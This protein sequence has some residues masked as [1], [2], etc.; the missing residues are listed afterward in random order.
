MYAESGC[1]IEHNYACI[2]LHALLTED[3]S[4]RCHA[5]HETQLQ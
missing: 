1:G 5:L 2:T 4:T 3:I